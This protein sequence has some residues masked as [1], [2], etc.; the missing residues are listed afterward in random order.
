MTDG[1]AFFGRGMYG[2]GGGGGFSCLV[3]YAAAATFAS[4]ALRPPWEDVA[5][6]R[7][8]M[9]KV[10]VACGRAGPDHYHQVLSLLLVTCLSDL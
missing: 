10:I 2:G 4:D 1:E 3:Q 6:R 9:N 8:L 7:M 5:R